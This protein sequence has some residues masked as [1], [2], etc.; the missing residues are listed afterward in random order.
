MRSVC[1]KQKSRLLLVYPCHNVR[2]DFF[3]KTYQHDQ[4]NKQ[5]LLNPCLP[6]RK[7]LGKLSLARYFESIRRILTA[8]FLGFFGLVGVFGVFGWE[9]SVGDSVEPTAMMTEL[10]IAN[11]LCS[12]AVRVRPCTIQLLVHLLSKTRKR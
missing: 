12:M 2:G 10:K 9:G 8:S 3:C 4:L 1:S 5:E 11:M 7:V 6:S